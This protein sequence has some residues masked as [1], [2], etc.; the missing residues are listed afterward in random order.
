MVV[1]SRSDAV[2]C[3]VAS[4]GSTA[5]YHPAFGESLTALMADATF[6]KTCTPELPFRLRKRFIACLAALALL[7]IVTPARANLVV[8]GSFETTS[9]AASGQVHFNTG[10]VTG[11]TASTGTSVQLG[12]L[13]F[14][15]HAK[16]ALT[17]Q[18]GTNDFQLAQAPTY[19]ASSPDG[20]KFL[21][22]D[23]APTYQGTFFQSISGLKVG[24]TYVLSFYQA[25]GQ[26]NGALYNQPTT[27]QWKVTFGGQTFL[28]TLMNNPVQSFT[29]WNTQTMRFTASATTQVLTFLS[30]GGPDG[31][32]PFVFLDGVNLVETTPEP[33]TLLYAGIGV[34]L[35]A[36]WR[37]RNKRT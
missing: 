35:I 12:F 6:N 10:D 2:S 23:A 19:P 30:Q 28:S 21:A 8:N 17:D 20:G 26:Q 24:W 33:S 7:A 18:F 29:A 22:V 15:G 13:Y 32:P 36:A 3:G 25:A 4:F 9:L 37:L 1:K 27:E 5:P 16:D 14:S 31:L 11:W 34:G